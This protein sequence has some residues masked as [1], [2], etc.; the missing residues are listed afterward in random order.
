MNTTVNEYTLPD[1]PPN[2]DWYLVAKQHQEFLT[3]DNSPEAQELLQTIA[4]Y[5]RRYAIK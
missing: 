1:L 3:S 2:Y 5:E 4:D